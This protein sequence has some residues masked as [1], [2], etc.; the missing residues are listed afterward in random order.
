MVNVNHAGRKVFISIVRR[1]RLIIMAY[2]KWPP[3]G[4]ELRRIRV[5]SA[6]CDGRN[7]TWKKL[8]TSSSAGGTRLIR[9]LHINETA[10]SY[11]CYRRSRTPLRKNVKQKKSDVHLRPIDGWEKIRG[12]AKK[13]R[14]WA[15]R[16]LLELSVF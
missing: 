16:I 2:K 12:G 11:L 14:N 6:T 1:S 3:L 7:Y 9:A 8:I 5:I 4:R 15:R 10:M 13:G